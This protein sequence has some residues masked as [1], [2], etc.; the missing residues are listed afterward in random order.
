MVSTTAH[1]LWKKSMAPNPPTPLARPRAQILSLN[2]SGNPVPASP[3]NVVNRT[4]CMYRCSRVKRTKY[5]LFVAADVVFA[6]GVCSNSGIFA[7]L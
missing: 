2:R 5:R 4:A 6:L 3:R 7:S 1:S